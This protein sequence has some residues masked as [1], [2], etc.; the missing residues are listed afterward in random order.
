MGASFFVFVDEYESQFNGQRPEKD[1]GESRT[2]IYRKNDSFRMRIL[3]HERFFLGLWTLDFGLSFS[4][5]HGV[6]GFKPGSCDTFQYA[7]V[8]IQ[9]DSQDPTVA[10]GPVHLDLVPQVSQS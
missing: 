1:Q 5:S 9:A 6:S 2:W 3:S 7:A 4:P 10:P 8:R